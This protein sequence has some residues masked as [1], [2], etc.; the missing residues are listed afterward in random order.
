M[1]IH[2]YQGKELFRKYGVPTPRGILALS[3]DEAEA[4]AKELAT[5][6]VVVKAQIHA[7]GRGKGGGV[8][9]AKS[10]AEAKALT[11]QILGMM[12][13]TIQTGP[14]GQKVHKVYIEEGLDI[15]Q[16]LYLGVTLD[17]ATSRVT[18]MASTEG[19]VE[20]EEV[21]EKH[22]EKILRAVV[23][24]AVGFADF[25]GRELA[26]G[27]GLSGPTVNKFVQFC[28]A[29]YRMYMETDASLVEINPLVIRKSGGVVAL[30][31]KV[32]FDENALYRHK[33]LLEYR[34]LAEEE[35]RETQAKEYD[36]AYIA[37]DGNI[38]CMVNGAG[39]AMATMDTIKLV[40]GAPAN[41]LDVGGGASKEKVTAA[42]KL[43]LADPQVKAV[44]V[45]IFG[46][47]MKCD[48]I[49][50][51]IIA[52][53]KEVQLKIPLIV[54]LEGTNVEQGK[55]LLRN[56]G[57]AITPADNLRQAAEKAVAAIK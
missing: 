43:I 37:L 31:A 7:G 4:A 40:G 6:V 21:A 32:T 33:D 5:P 42:F 44:L 34:D 55:E 15:G 52:A 24:P 45:N 26:F 36:L 35:P 3:P 20:I 18:F 46:G 17:R 27:L 10:P 23:D 12:L 49:A 2:E 56:S 1:K 47:I 13:K 11:Q 30:D 57:L 25:Q 53:A 41:F 51:G 39:L 29:L 19:G 8:K 14:E 9:L 16:E 38:G 28:S 54:R 50:D 48:V 22:P